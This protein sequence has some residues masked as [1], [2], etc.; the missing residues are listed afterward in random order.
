MKNKGMIYC[1]RCGG[2][3]EKKHKEIDCMRIE[4][5][6]MEQEWKENDF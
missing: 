5:R 1:K 4:Q 6:E 2:F 3:Y